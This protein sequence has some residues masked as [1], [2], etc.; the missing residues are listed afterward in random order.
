M[1]LAFSLLI[2]LFLG[3]CSYNSVYDDFT[4]I[5]GGNWHYKDTVNF[6]FE[7]TDTTQFCDF[8]LIVRHD[9]DYHYSNFI[10]FV[11]LEFPNGR[12]RMDTVEMIL[13]A[14]NGKWLGQGL[15]DIY[16]NEQIYL[17]RNRFPLKGEYKFQILH[18]MRDELLLGINDVGIA[19]RKNEH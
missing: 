5:K 1:R 2:I 19:I 15:G 11:R 7:V 3:S 10:S 4:V 6:S 18:A 8:S 14:S 17:E 12:A 9:N 13:A 16:S